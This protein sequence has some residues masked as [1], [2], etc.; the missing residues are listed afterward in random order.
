MLLTLGICDA[1]LIKFYKKTLIM[2]FLTEV[3]QINE[4]VGDLPISQITT[5]NFR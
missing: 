1:A 2:T 3:S 5:V 4:N